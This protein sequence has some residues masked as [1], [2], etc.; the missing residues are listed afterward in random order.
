M[1]K[2]RDKKIRHIL[3]KHLISKPLSTNELYGIVREEIDDRRFGLNIG[4]IS[5]NL[6][7]LRNINKVEDEVLKYGRIWSA[8]G[9]LLNDK[10]E[11]STR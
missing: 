2:T 9:E 5:A 6:V 7:Y 10:E 11:D 8:T 3:L 1:K 4:I